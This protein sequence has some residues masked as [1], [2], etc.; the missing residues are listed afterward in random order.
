LRD[1]DIQNASFTCSFCGDCEWSHAFSGIPHTRYWDAVADSYD[2]MYEKYWSCLENQR[3]KRLLS[4]LALPRVPRVVDLGC[5]T[6]LGYEIVSE[7]CGTVDY[8]GID[9]SPKM[10]ARFRRKHPQ[11][12][13]ALSTMTRLATGK[14]LGIDLIMLLFSTGSCVECLHHLLNAA[15][16]HLR[17]G[18]WVY[19]SV[20]SRYSLRRTVR[21]LTKWSRYEMYRT[22]GDRGAASVPV[23]TYTVSEIRRMLLSSG[24]D[25]VTVDGVNALSGVAELRPLWGLGSTLAQLIPSLSHQVEIVARHSREY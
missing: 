24:F 17:V 23:R 10:L 20:L 16:K 25:E 7:L 18:G 3:V 13:T 19:I 8:L 2:Q 9:S 1:A 14:S 11:A 12:R 21:T 6:G 4:S 15:R 22:R 5:G